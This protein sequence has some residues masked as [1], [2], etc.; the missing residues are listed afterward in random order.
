MAGLSP[1][2]GMLNQTV[3]LLQSNKPFTST[4]QAVSLRQ[5]ARFLLAYRKS[6]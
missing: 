3:R 1:A 5:T 2:A 4:K 6:V